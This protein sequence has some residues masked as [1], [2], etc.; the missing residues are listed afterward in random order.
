MRC[1][2]E[3]EEER[4]EAVDGGGCQKRGTDA[5]SLRMSPGSR[6]HVASLAFRH[7]WIACPRHPE[8]CQALRMVQWLTAERATSSSTQAPS[9]SLVQKQH[10]APQRRGRA[11]FQAAPSSRFRVD[12]R[13]RYYTLTHNACDRHTVE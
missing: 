12:G 7:K 2:E 3:R 6:S 8:V 5:P 9:F 13:T 4:G 1:H 11:I 10:R